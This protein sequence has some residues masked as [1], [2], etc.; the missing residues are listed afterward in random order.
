MEVPLHHLDK[1]IVHR[2]KKKG[3]VTEEV[4]QAYLA[5]LPD[6]SE[7]IDVPEPEEKEPAQT[8]P[9]AD[10]LETSTD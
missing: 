10:S 3:L 1:R 8:A 4:L 7:N 2:S 5:S 9:E 6:R